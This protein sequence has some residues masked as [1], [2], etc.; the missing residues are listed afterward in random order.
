AP[1]AL[2]QLV[3][4][5]TLADE[6]DGARLGV[7]RHGPDDLPGAAVSDQSALDD[8]VRHPSVRIEIQRHLVSLLPSIP[9][10]AA[11]NG[12]GATRDGRCVSK[13]A[14]ELSIGASIDVDLS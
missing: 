3:G 1:S 12:A 14:R 8:D 7:V 2:H 9:K 10:H 4:D 6:G 5:Q 13:R 11:G